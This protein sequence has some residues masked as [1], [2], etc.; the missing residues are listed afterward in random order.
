[1]YNMLK[2]IWAHLSSYLPARGARLCERR[3]AGGT[4]KRLSEKSSHCPTVNCQLWY[5]AEALI[6]PADKLALVRSAE[7]LRLSTRLDEG[8]GRLWLQQHP[9]GEGPLAALSNEP[10]RTCTSCAF[11]HASV[12][13][14]VANKQTF[15]ALL[16]RVKVEKFTWFWDAG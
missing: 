5:G 11:S 16:S 10:T 8:K 4:N 3:S 13:V 6:L 14:S 7:P 9:L 12:C 1:M 15:C 2:E